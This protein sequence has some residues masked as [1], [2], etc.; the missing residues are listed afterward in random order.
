MNKLLEALS[1][2]LGPS[3]NADETVPYVLTT[4]LPNLNVI[5]SDDPGGGFPGGRIISISGPASSGKTA[6]ATE[7]MIQAQ[8]AGG[9]AAF[10]DYEHAFLMKHAV[11]Q[12]L[13]PEAMFYKQPLTAEEGFDTL[14][15]VMQITRAQE[16]GID[17]AKFESSKAD[18]SGQRRFLEKV[19]TYDKKKL[20]PLVLVVDSIAA[21]VP[22]ESDIGY[23]DQNMRTKNMALAMFLSVEM[24]RIARDSNRLAA[25]VVLLNQLRTNPT[26]SFGDSK[27]EPGGESIPFYASLRLRLRKVG[28]VYDTW[29]D[30]ASEPVGDIVEAVV[31]KNKVARPFRKTQYVFRTNNGP[32]GLD[33]P[34]TLIHLGKEGGLIG[35]K[36][37][38][39]VTIGGT[40]QSAKDVI[41]KA[42]NDPKLMKELINLVIPPI[43]ST[44]K[45]EHPAD[46]GVSVES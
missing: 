1:D 26:I 37:G 8:R 11:N 33:L 12:G 13:D 15:K 24:K 9:F 7:L 40:R 23:V 22:E 27:T 38:T 34:A 28:K 31:A 29:G 17:L 36:S 35:A 19:S 46:N 20:K 6:L 10:N 45:T 16:L 18:P 44:L 39:T 2:K 21:M 32:V 3:A 5:V 25:T 42:R 41:V 4:S 14:Y 30:T 43:L